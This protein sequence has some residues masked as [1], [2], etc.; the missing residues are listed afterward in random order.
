MLT[1]E[2]ITTREG[3]EQLGSVWNPLLEASASNNLMLTWEWLTTWWDVFGDERELYLLLVRDGDELIGI[4]PLLRRA[5]QHYGLLPFERLEFLA[6]GEDEAD[7]I[8]SDYLDFILR[9]GREAEALSAIFRHLCE[10]ET[11]WDEWLLTDISAESPNLPLIEKLGCQKG[12]KWEVTRRQICVYCP[13]PNDWETFLHRLRP[14]FRNRIRRERRR[15]QQYDCELRVIES[16]EGFAENF[17]ILIHLHQA[18]WNSRGQPGVFS[19]E[20]FTRFHRLVA[21]KLLRQ[22]WLRLYVLLLDGEPVSTYYG[23]IYHGK[24]YFYQAGC[25]DGDKRIYSP[26]T[27]IKSFAIEH[28]I[29]AGCSEFDMLKSAPDSYKFRW[30]GATR[31]IIQARLAPHQTKETFYQM[32]AKCTAGLR[33]IKSAMQRRATASDQL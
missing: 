12:M 27:I 33:Q 23:F 22:G 6:S 26:G 8:C 19:S 29:A 4:A 18:R 5:V 17:E 28:S 32:A 24:V 25:V 15:L 7:E 16:E 1:I 9:R 13:L 2:K 31:G 20:K 21:P 3:F 10:Q 11:E 14:T 30:G